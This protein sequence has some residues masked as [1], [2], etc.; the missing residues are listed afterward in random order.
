MFKLPPL[1]SYTPYQASEFWP[2]AGSSTPSSVAP[3]Q[4]STAQL[5]NN[6]YPTPPTDAN[7]GLKPPGQTSVSPNS[8]ATTTVQQPGMASNMDPGGTQSSLTARRP[9]ANNLPNVN[10]PPLPFKHQ[11]PH[12]VVPLDMNYEQNMQPPQNSHLSSGNLLTPPTPSQGALLSPI[13]TLMQNANSDGNSHALPPYN[14]NTQSWLP[15]PTGTTPLG[16]STGSTPSPW[17]S[18]LKGLFSPSILQP[19]ARN[20]SGSDSAS[21]SLPPPPFES[22][23]QLFPISSGMSPPSTLPTASG[24]QQPFVQQAQ[25]LMPQAQSQAQTQ[26][27]PSPTAI[28]SPSTGAAPLQSERPPSA[29]L[30]YQYSLSQPASAQQTSFPPF[31]S[32][33]QQSPM[34]APLIGTSRFSPTAL[35]QPNFQSAA[36]QMGANAFRPFASSYNGLPALQHAQAPVSAPILTNM[37][38]PGN[39]MSL[40]GMPTY[41]IPPNGMQ[42]NPPMMPPYHSGHAAQMYGNQP[43]SPP[44][45]RPFKCDTCPQSF[46]RNHDLK[47]HKRIH[48]AVKPF[49][50]LHCEKSFSRKDALKVSKLSTSISGITPTNFLRRDIF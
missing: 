12:K 34:S 4:L 42:P 18:Q 43:R 19:I 26:N 22:I 13:S 24:P 46:N 27:Q 6:P 40:M 35:Q 14:P 37:Q 25:Q 2:G 23:P 10:L 29:S 32:S 36:A 11:P 20:N 45:E 38:N 9:A 31:T 1:D 47:R 50:C 39:Q 44:N 15:P 5:P 49:P 48:L 41:G 30:E 8:P 17:S 3:S 7:L 28:Q 33:V 21:A 16:L